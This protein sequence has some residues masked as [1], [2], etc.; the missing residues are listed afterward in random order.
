[1]RTVID[2]FRTG[3][4]FFSPDRSPKR[5]WLRRAGGIAALCV[6]FCLS[7]Q[8][9]EKTEG[10]ASIPWSVRAVESL[11]RYCPDSVAYPGVAKSNRWDYERGVVL[12]GVWQVYNATGEKKYFSYLKKNIDQ[13]VEE[14][15]SIKT[16]DYNTFNIDNIATGRNLL[17]LYAKTGG[18]KYKIAAD[19]LRKQLAHQPRTLEGGFWHK[20][21]YPFQMWLDGL[22]MGEP[23]YAEYAK[24]FNEPADYKDIVNQ[25]IFIERHTRDPKTGLLYH[26]WDESKQMPWADKQT[27]RSPHFWGRAIGWYAWAIVDVLE[28]LPRDHPGRKELIAILNRLSAALLKVREPHSKLWYQVLDQGKRAGN[29]LESSGSSMFVYAFAKGAKKGYLD[30]KY[31]TAARESFKGILDSMVTVDNQGIVN[32]H[33]ACQG[34]GLGGNP[35]RD[36]SYEY[37][38]GEKQRTND[39]KAVGPFILAALELKQ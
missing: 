7:V 13:F 3:H 28:Y 27:G 15:G 17:A 29:Y 16:Y 2:L 30:K 37:Y 10:K 24:M 5:T 26:A 6:L 8:C 1:M 4:S 34:A 11:M 33:H 14:N 38:I 36:G 21:I 22:Y 19:T 20:K 35:Y 23:F 32:L 9:G 31:L 39:F 18:K 12:Q 25:F